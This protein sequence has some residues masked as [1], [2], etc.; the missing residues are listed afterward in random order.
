MIT[1]IRLELDD[2]KRERIALALTGKKGLATRAQIVKYVEGLIK[3]DFNP[4]GE[5]KLVPCACPKC[6]RPI[7]VRVRVG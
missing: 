6:R 3:A 5:V 4:S 7:S 1:N 2:A